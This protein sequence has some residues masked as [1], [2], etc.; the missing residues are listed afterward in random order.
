MT[1]IIVIDQHPL[2]DSRIQ[3]HIQ[4]VHTKGYTV[5]RINI[6]RKLFPQQSSVVPGM[7]PCY[8]LGEAIT[9]N[10]KINSA[11]YNMKAFLGMFQQFHQIVE[12]LGLKLTEKTI[13]HVHDPI[14][15][16][17]ASKIMHCFEEAKLVYDRHEVYENRSA[18]LPHIYLP[19][20]GRFAEIMTC[21]K[22]S[23]VI[24]VADSYCDAVEKLFPQA[25]VE[26]VPNY[27]VLSE[28]NTDKILSKIKH[29]N[30]K[31][32][33]NFI[34]VGSLNWN[35]DRD[36]G[37]LLYLFDELQSENYNIKF[38]IGGKTDDKLLLNELSHRQQ[39]Y[40]EK[41]IYMGYISHDKVIQLT[42]EA[43]FGFLLIRPETDY[44]VLTS[45]N[46]VFEYLRCGVIPVLRVKCTC[47]A[48]LTKCSLWFERNDSKEHILDEIKKIFNDPTKIQEMMMCAYRMSEMFSY[49]NVAKRYLLIYDDL[50]GLE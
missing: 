9:T 30:H 29:V 4:Y 27:P 47:E 45:P 34:Y 31:T 18:W 14:L 33:L 8:V 28:Y 38:I 25:K 43:H 19:A 10:P 24:T 11:F 3:R 35:N 41:C 16:P 23:G 6:N 5:Y 50:L 17:Y 26:S 15:L 44:W 46:K 42:E 32:T 20:I 7:I 37:L 39:Q 40:P 12:V 21:K 2:Q 1:Q 36:I 22:I 49:E 13:V 48:E